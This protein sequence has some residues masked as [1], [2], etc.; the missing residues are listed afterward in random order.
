V[1]LA[2]I[3]FAYFFI[4]LETDEKSKI[5]IDVEENFGVENK[6][7]KDTNE[8]EKHEEH[9]GWLWDPNNEEWVPDPEYS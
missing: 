3:T 9:P 7:E 5:S 2:I 4:E 6:S 1:V 8:L